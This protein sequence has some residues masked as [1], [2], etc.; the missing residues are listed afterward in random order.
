[1]LELGDTSPDAVRAAAETMD[2]DLADADVEEIAALAASFTETPLA[3]RL[4]SARRV[5]REHAFAFPLDPA[6]PDGPLL[7]GVVD[8]LAEEADGTLLVVDYKTNPVEGQDLDAVVEAHY[9]TQRTIYALAALRTGAA[10]VEVAYAFLVR[11]TEPVQA[12]YGQGDAERL[13]SELRADAQGLLRGEYPVAEH[14]HR[15]LCLT[16]PGRGGL[17]SWPQD[18]VLQ[19]LQPSPP[20]PA[21]R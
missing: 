8:V 12:T 5:H 20:A 7:N 17:C 10:R 15:E 16:C 18:R 21:S 2:A 1:V 6:D 14:P 19:P 4:A 3:G 9:A 13:T 11:P